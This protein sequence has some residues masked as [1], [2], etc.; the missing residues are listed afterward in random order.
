MSGAQVALLS[1][2]TPV[3][4][5]EILVPQLLQ[6][7]GGSGAVIV[8]ASGTVLCSKGVPASELALLGGPPREGELAPGFVALPLR[9]GRLGVRTSP[10]SPLFGAGEAGL[11]AGI[12]YLTDLSLQRVLLL[13]AERAALSSVAAANVQ[14]QA[15]RQEL[16]SA[17]DRALEASRMKSQFLA[18]MSHE[19]RTPM[20]GVIGMTSL[21]LE[22][23]LDVD[24]RDYAET[25]RSS[26]EG[27]L[28][29]IDDILDF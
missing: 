7:L 4:V 10:F 29:V 13:G 12:V 22:T 3:E 2:G 5:A 18:N 19:I 6:V 23:E 16:E 24:Q 8:D 1:A 21:L 9:H 11:L 17:H 25:V 26:A 28:T 15:S 27:L 14:L 20:N